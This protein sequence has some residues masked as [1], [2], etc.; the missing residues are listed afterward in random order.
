MDYKM[1]D[2]IVRNYAGQPTYS[3]SRAFTS[4]SVCHIS[5]FAR[6][7]AGFMALCD[8]GKVRRYDAQLSS[9]ENA[10]A[11]ADAVYGLEKTYG[12]ELHGA[13]GAGIYHDPPAVTCTS[14]GRH[15]ERPHTSVFDL[16][17][18]FF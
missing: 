12:K 11:R 1:R 5:P 17:F 7:E 9:Y 10:G 16:R 3:G 6:R 14:F 8:D 15:H 2:G 18:Y 13:V 4:Y